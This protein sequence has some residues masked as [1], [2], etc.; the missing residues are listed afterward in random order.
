LIDCVCGHGDCGKHRAIY[1]KWLVNGLGEELKNIVM[2]PTVRLDC[3]GGHEFLF[4]KEKM[5]IVRFQI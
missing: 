4:A 2:Q 5:Q 1:T 3:E